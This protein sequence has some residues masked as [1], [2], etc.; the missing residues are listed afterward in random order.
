MRVHPRHA[1]RP[2]RRR[3]VPSGTTW[4]DRSLVPDRQVCVS[5][6]LKHHSL[7]GSLRERRR[8]QDR[9]AGHSEK[10]LTD[11]VAQPDPN[12]P[13]KPFRDVTTDQVWSPACAVPIRLA[14]ITRRRLTWPAPGIHVWR[15]R[16]L[17]RMAGEGRWEKHADPA[18]TN[19][20][21]KRRTDS[22]LMSAGHPGVGSTA[23]ARPAA[24]QSPR[25]RRGS[26]SSARTGSDDFHGDARRN[27]RLREHRDA[28]VSIRP[29]QRQG[30]PTGGASSEVRHRCEE[31][32]RLERTT[33]FQQVCGGRARHAG[34]G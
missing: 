24:R 33:G 3:S 27:A 8:R 2:S 30:A 17:G 4:M 16:R 14:Q 34:S 11:S 12:R 18:N 10:R 13:P 25:A 22:T 5:E 28:P 29:G 21:V 9:R 23:P 32:K 6:H 15:A 19:I 7:R 1:R 31:S 26:S 20:S